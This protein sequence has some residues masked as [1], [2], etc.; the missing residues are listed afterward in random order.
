VA[1]DYDRDGDLDLFVGGRIVPGSY[2][3]PARSLLLRNDS[4]PGSPRFTDVTQSVAPG[5]D[6]AGLVT[7]ALWTDFDRDGQVDLVVAGEWMPLTF[8]R[9]RGGRLVDVTAS[10]GLEKSHGWWNSLTAGD[11]DRDGD[12]DYLAGNMGLNSRFKASAREPVRVQARDFDGNGSVDPVLSYYLDGKS[13]PVAPRDVLIDQI[14]GMKGRFKRYAD[15]A[16]AT[17]DRMFSREELDSAYVAESYTMTSSMVENLGNGRFALRALPIPA[18][19]APA[20][21]MLAT[22]RNGD[23]ALDILM[24][25]NSYASETTFGWYDAS[26]GVVLLGNGRGGFSN[27]GYDRSGFF[28]DGDAKGAAELMVDEHRSLV[29]VT[30]NNDSL[31]VFESTR[32][33]CRNVRLEPLDAYA[34]VT[35]ANG[36]TMREEFYYGSTYLSQSSRFLALPAAATRVVI[37]DYAGKPRTVS[38]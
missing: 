27:V 10:T 4:R 28:V 3:L 22:D 32:E 9:N 34:V 35:L 18:Q 1:A 23:G 20:Y 21:G 2:P 25:G 30:Q 8:F 15:Y 7:S 19:F 36:S 38:L 13:Y 37:Y 24:V 31:K 26:I 14:I 16:T 12:V 6:H 29:L 33:G 11:F 5:L 17:V